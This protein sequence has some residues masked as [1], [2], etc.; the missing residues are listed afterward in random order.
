MLSN[1]FYFMIFILF[2]IILGVSVI[3]LCN[4]PQLEDFI[5]NIRARSSEPLKEEVD[6]VRQHIDEIKKDLE[7]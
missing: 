3:G 6:G 2:F 1:D 5:A 4:L 7:E